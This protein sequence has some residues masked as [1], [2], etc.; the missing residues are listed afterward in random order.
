[1]NLRKFVIPFLLQDRNK[2]FIKASLSQDVNFNKKLA[3]YCLVKVDYED[4]RILASPLPGNG[5]GDFFQLRDSDGFMELRPEEGPF[6]KG[7]V[8]E[9]YL[10]GT[11]C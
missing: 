4:D 10:W 8:S 2:T 5:S 11:Q 6:E 1:V 9:L 7:F 3:Y